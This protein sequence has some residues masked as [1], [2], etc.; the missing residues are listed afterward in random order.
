M[1]KSS[2]LDIYTIYEKLI[3]SSISQDCAEEIMYRQQAGKKIEIIIERIKTG[4]KRD[5][6]DEMR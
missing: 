4:F 3:V 6:D 2:I 1:Q 5:K